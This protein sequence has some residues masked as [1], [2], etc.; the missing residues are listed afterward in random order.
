[1][2]IL[3]ASTT[4][5]VAIALVALLGYWVGRRRRCSSDFEELSRTSAGEAEQLIARIE[6][7]SNQLRQSLA[8]SHCTVTRYREEVRVLSERHAADVD[9]APHMHW[10]AVLAP[11]ERLSHDL[12][13][14]YDEL[15]R[16]THALTSLRT[17]GSGYEGGV[18]TARHQARTPVRE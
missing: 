5:P 8:A 18:K 6:S 1:M 7:I 15:R 10:Q 16:H 13:A 4:A 2:D 17:H 12:A 11:T 3:V 9:G 14:A